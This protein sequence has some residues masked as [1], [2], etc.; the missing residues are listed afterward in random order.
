[1]RS[2]MICVV[3]ISMVVMFQNVEADRKYLKFLDCNQ[4]KPPPFCALLKNERFPKLPKQYNRGC[5]AI[6]GICRGGAAG[7]KQSNP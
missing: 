2:W 1:M 4:S 6:T 3:L 7:A 5:S